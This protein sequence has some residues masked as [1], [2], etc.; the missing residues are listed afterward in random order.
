MYKLLYASRLA[1]YGLPAQ[2][3]QYCEQIATVLLGQD[4]A[5]HPIL[6]QQ[7]MKVSLILPCILAGT[8]CRRKHPWG[9]PWLGV[10][11]SSEHPPRVC[12]LVCAEYSEAN[13]SMQSLIPTDLG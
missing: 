4:M 10:L 3:L 9:F 6:A 7:V 12:C 11:G 5:S 13:A 1:D 2:A 8:R